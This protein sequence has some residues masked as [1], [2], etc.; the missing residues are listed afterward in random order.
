LS[1]SGSTTI[2]VDAM[3]RDHAPAPEVD[4]AKRAVASDRSLR[5]TLV[6]DR[7]ELAAL[8]DGASERIDIVRSRGSARRSSRRHSA[9]SRSASTTPRSV[10]RSSP[11]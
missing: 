11:A 3:G 9:A 1:S 4:G 5:V 10:A 2:V 6:G 7:A 8:L